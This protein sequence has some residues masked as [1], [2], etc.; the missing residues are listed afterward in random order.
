MYHMK[1][2]SPDTTITDRLGRP[3]RIANTG[4]VVHELLA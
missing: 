3:I 1:G 2:I 4:E